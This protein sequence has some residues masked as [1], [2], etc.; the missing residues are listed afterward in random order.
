[1]AVLLPHSGYAAHCNEFS[2]FLNSMSR[3]VHC[4]RQLRL[5]VL[6]WPTSS[7][8]AVLSLLPDGLKD[9][10]SYHSGSI[11]GDWAGSTPLPSAPLGP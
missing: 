5:T 6:R 1:M 10:A 3:T 9:A 4:A 11:R 7:Y 8:H 2:A